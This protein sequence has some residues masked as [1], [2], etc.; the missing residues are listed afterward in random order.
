VDTRRLRHSCSR[1][2]EIRNGLQTP[3]SRCRDHLEMQESL[4]RAPTRQVK[5][6]AIRRFLPQGSRSRVRPGLPSR[7]AA[8]TCPQFQA[9]P[10]A[11]HSR[12]STSERKT[13]SMK[14]TSEPLIRIRAGRH[15]L[16]NNLGRTSVLLEAA[17][18]GT[19]EV[20]LEFTRLKVRSRAP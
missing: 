1:C 14:A 3:Q 7:G 13:V 11:C 5:L 4:K 16:G 20:C 17:T 19:V 8:A 9:P 2:V 15:S 18:S 10:G 6:S 12:P